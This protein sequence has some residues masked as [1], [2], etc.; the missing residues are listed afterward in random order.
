MS[1]FA[2]CRNVFK[3]L[4]AA[5]MQKASIRRKGFTHLIFLSFLNVFTPVIAV[6][7]RVYKHL[8]HVEIKQS[9]IY[10]IKC[11]KINDM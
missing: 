2:Q 9:M 4:L 8:K 6:R 11:F 10:A 7:E 1:N 5:E 3:S